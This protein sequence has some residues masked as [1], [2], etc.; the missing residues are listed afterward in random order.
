MNGEADDS[1]LN[2]TVSNATVTVKGSNTTGGGTGGGGTGGGGTGGG[3]TGGSTG[4]GSTPSK[5]T[6]PPNPPILPSRRLPPSP[7]LRLPAHHV[8]YVTGYE[9]KTIRPDN[10]ITRAEAAA[11][12]S[13]ISSGFDAGKS[14]DVSRFSD[15]DSGAWFAKNVG[16][17]AENSIVNG[18]EDATFRPESTIT[19]EEF[20]AML[21][22]FMKLDV[23]AGEVFS[24]VPAEP[25]GITVY[26][27]DESKRYHRRI[28][29]RFFRLRQKY[30]TRRSNR[31]DQPCTRTRSE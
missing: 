22:R 15:V 7:Q 3:S 9:D 12:I 13:R 10:N 25:L 26:C 5:P 4:G 2:I 14:Y 23:S 6:I 29:G 27:G 31:N 28:R 8:A 21:C 16:Y 19:R 20:A 30:N 11:L 17:A 24:D 18:Y 1:L